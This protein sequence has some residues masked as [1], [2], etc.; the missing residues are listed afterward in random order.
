MVVLVI[1]LWD[2][3]RLHWLKKS[4]KARQNRSIYL[5][6]SAVERKDIGAE[7][8]TKALEIVCSSNDPDWAEKKWDL[9]LKL[10]R[11]GVDVNKAYSSG[12]RSDHGSVLHAACKALDYWAVFV[13]LDHGADPLKTDGRQLTPLALLEKE[14]DQGSLKV[15]EGE[16][17]HTHQQSED[18]KGQT[19]QQ[20][21]RVARTPTPQQIEEQKRERGEI[22]KLLHAHLGPLCNQV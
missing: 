11:A 16:K 2:F 14:E 7:L 19:P 1:P 13:L 5:L 22:R 9:V 12:S 4:W 3:L 10:V 17:D 6:N 18:E 15:V 21:A 8:L 20:D